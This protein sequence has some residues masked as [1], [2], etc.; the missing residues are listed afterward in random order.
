MRKGSWQGF[1]CSIVILVFVLLLPV[2]AAGD[3]LI[4]PLKAIHKETPA[5]NRSKEQELGALCKVKMVRISDNP[6]IKTPPQPDLKV[7]FY[8]EFPL[9]NPAVNH[10]FLIDFE[11]KEKLFWVDSDA[12]QEY[13]TEASYAIF[14]SDRY[15]GLNIYC[16]PTPVIIQASYTID[17]HQFRTELQFEMPYLYVLRNWLQDRFYLMTRTW[18]MGVLPVGDEELTL[19]LVDSNDNGNYNDP[20]DLLFIDSNY[21]LNFN[22]KEGKPLRSM[23]QLKVKSGDKYELDFHCCPEKLILKKR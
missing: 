22:S 17:D 7:L 21:D 5:F 6:L 8:G 15:P 18:F 12:N 2:D 14:K 19:A 1:V 20:D 13:A 3:N 23:K 4:I 16:S 9:G 10:G 11:G